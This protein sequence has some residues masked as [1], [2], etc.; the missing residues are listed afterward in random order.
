M[1]IK[2][3]FGV[4]LA[5]LLC[6]PAGAQQRRPAGK[7]PAVAAKKPV[8]VQKSSKFAILQ[9]DEWVNRQLW[10]RCSAFLRSLGCR[11]LLTNDNNGR[12]HGEGEPVVIKNANYVPDNFVYICFPPYSALIIHVISFAFWLVSNRTFLGSLNMIL[13]DK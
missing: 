5:V 1:N 10:E 4:A 13:R 7:K 12:W 2:H 6:L 9:F 3:F 11:A 8:S